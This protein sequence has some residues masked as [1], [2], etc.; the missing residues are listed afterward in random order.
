MIERKRYIG[1]LRPFFHKDIVKV[2]TGLRRSGK[3]VL[4][5][6]VMEALRADGAD[7]AAMLYSLQSLT[8]GRAA[9]AS[10]STRSK[11]WTTGSAS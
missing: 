10:F 4:L 5:Q 1:R 9:C 7:P 11:K 6:Q 3:S 8:G 2:L